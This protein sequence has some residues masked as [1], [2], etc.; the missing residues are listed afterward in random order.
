MNQET[1]TN[2]STET[3][4]I[5]ETPT[6]D[7]ENL[8][9]DTTAQQFEDLAEEFDEED[10]LVD[11]EGQVTEEAPK[12]PA[13][14]PEKQETLEQPQ[15]QEPAPEPVPEEA[16]Q[17]QEKK[18]EPETEKPP[19]EPE[20]E[21]AIAETTEEQL[22]SYKKSREVSL[23]AIEELYAVTEEEDIERLRSEPE[24]AMPKMAAE[25]F[26]DLHETV[27]KSVMT[28]LPQMLSNI[29]QQQAAVQQADLAFSEA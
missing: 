5:T 12:E 28:M 10:G 1:L 16:K 17:P 24:K 22:E 21:P 15:E 13:P 29:T 27:V 8:G 18:P 20:P 2:E 26:L 7:T 3:S 14:E 11:T 19:V 4:E 6:E 23:K 25:M 9:E